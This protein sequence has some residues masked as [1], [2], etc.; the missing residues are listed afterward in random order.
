MSWHYGG[1]STSAT[2][3]RALEIEPEKAF[4][5]YF[6]A[7]CGVFGFTECRTVGELSGRFRQC[8]GHKTSLYPYGK[9]DIKDGK[10][11]I[12][13]GG[14]ND[15]EMLEEIVK[16]GVNCFV[17][18]ITALN[19]HSR[20]AHDYAKRRSLNILGGTHYSTEKFACQAMCGYFQRLGLTCEF[21]EGQPSLEDL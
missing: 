1:Y 21:M 12:I 7:L 19:D 9:E 10:V 13:A 20:K 11:A 17:T 8:V 14:G 6:G 15:V 3:A 2:L 16:E 5:P 18:G 4:A